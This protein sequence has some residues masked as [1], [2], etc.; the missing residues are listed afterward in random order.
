MI[1][2]LIAVLLSILGKAALTGQRCSSD[3]S[4]LLLPFPGA[5]ANTV[6]GVQAPGSCLP[7][8][9][10]IVD[11]CC[12]EQCRM[13]RV[14]RWEPG[15]CSVVC[16]NVHGVKTPFQEPGPHPV[17]LAAVRAAGTKVAAEPEWP[18]APAALG[19]CA[20]AKGRMEGRLGTSRAYP[21]WP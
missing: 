19:D 17:L 10:R 8:V 9:L 11:G 21:G 16:K 7:D 5:G 1:K 2:V 6:L 12:Q 4:T 13:L 20:R 15:R 18:L 14:H 3:T